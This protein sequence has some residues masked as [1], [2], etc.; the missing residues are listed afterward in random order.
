MVADLGSALEPA[1]DG[2]LRRAPE[3][4][5]DLVVTPNADPTPEVITGSPASSAAAWIAARSRSANAS[6]L[7]IA[8]AVRSRT[9]I[10]PATEPSRLPLN[11]PP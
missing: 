10:V 8:D 11:D 3:A 4:G 5:G 6:I 7:A 9:A 2:D 1:L